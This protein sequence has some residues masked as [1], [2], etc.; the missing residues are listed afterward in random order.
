MVSEENSS[1]PLKINEHQL[2]TISI[3]IC[4]ERIL[5]SSFYEASLLW[6]QNQIKTVSQKKTVDS[7]THELDCRNTHEIINSFQQCVRDLYTMMYKA[8][9]AGSM[10]KNK[11]I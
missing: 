3:K 5:P 1:K 6:Y 8:Y 7:I 9:K 11:I 10:F 2:Y 4:E